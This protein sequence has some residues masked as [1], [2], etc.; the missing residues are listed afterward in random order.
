MNEIKSFIIKHRRFLED[1][2]SDNR[3]KYQKVF[4]DLDRLERYI[5]ELTPIVP[6]FVA[7]WY[8]SHKDDIDFNVW[9]EIFE[10]EDYQY[11]E[12]SIA[13]WINCTDNAITI[14]INMHQFGYKVETEETEKQYRVKMKGNINDNILVYGSGI[15]RYFFSSNSG[16]NKRDAH[17]LKELEEAGFSEVFDNPLFE[18]E[19]VK[20]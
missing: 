2:V 19:E 7:D 18:V 20:E 14:L 4:N 1:L 11:S 13:N 6:Q 12:E 8:E 16:M 15:Q 10:F 9:N 5:D 17:T 3:S